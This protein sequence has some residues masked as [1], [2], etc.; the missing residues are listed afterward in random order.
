MVIGH[1]EQLWRYPVKSM[2]GETLDSA[3][4]VVEGMAGDR[5]WAVIDTDRDD[6]CGAKRWPELLNMKASMGADFHPEAFIYDEDVPGAGIELPDG[7]AFN[8]R[9]SDAAE[10][11]SLSLGKP[12]RFAPLAPPER[13]E[14][15]RLSHPPTEEEFK[16]QMG[17]GANEDLPDFSSIPEEIMLQLIEHA[18]PMGTYHDVFPLHLLTTNSLDFLSQ[19]GGVNAVVER[20]RPSM[21]VRPTESSPEMTENSWIG[22]SLQVGECLLHVVSR[23]VRCSMP[24]RPQHWAG[25]DAQG[26]ITR[27]LIEHCDR[28]LGVNVRVT[29]PGIIRANDEIQLIE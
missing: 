1:V 11:L 29:K 3:Q 27:A 21:L 16:A 14:H 28:H 12:A 23:T 6:I 9:D 5:C 13:G 2:A 15:Y 25:L 18:T 22:K 7:E 4:I 17:V 20:F 19:S 8:T 10:R 26:K 24:A